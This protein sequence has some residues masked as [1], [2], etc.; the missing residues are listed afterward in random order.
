M[1]VEKLVFNE[2][3]KILLMASHHNNME[4]EEKG[5]DQLSLIL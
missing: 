3:S 1:Y 4:R 5:T 2:I